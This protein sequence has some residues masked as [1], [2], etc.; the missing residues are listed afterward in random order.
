M[1][2]ILVL[3]V[4]DSDD[5]VRGVKGNVDE[6]PGFLGG[7]NAMCEYRIYCCSAMATHTKPCCSRTK[8]DPNSL[9]SAIILLWI[10][11][12]DMRLRLP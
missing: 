5:A 10:P 1:Q 8:S 11:I 3:L 9:E 2:V 6:R 12:R 4:R 7:I